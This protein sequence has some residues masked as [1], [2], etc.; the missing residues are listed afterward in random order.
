[1]RFEQLAQTDA[2][3][4]FFDLSW[5]NDSLQNNQFVLQ[6]LFSEPI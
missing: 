1:M 6:D 2:L 4:Q 5:V 3:L